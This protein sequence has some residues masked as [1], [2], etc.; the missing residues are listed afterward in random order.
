[1]SCHG[2]ACNFCLY[3]CELESCYFTPGEIESVEDICF[4][5][6]ECKWFDGNWERK[7]SQ[8]RAECPRFREPIKRTEMMRIVSDRRA[9]K[10]RNSFV[11]IKGAD[12]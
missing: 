6:D 5:C 4:A 3:N 2:C 8:W 1:M 11:V 9:Q 12:T 10:F 7:R